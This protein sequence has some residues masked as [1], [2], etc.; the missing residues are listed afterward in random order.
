MIT[1]INLI[2]KICDL[3]RVKRSTESVAQILGMG[4]LCVAQVIIDWFE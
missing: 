3:Y 4:E 1:D 2:L